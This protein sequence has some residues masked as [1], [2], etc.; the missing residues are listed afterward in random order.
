MKKLERYRKNGFDFT[1]LK[2]KGN[3]AIFRGENK[4]ISTYE[5]IKVKS[6]NGMNLHGAFIEAKEYPPSDEEWGAKG[7]TFQTL[8]GAENKFNELEKSVATL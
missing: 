4:G 5:V 6:H 8:K 3:I 2:R 1:E 7:W